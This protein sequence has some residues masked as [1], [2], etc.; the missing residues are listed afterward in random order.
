MER[1]AATEYAPYYGKYVGLVTEDDLVAALEVQL[2]ETLAFLRGVAE[3]DATVLHLSYTWTIKEVV[4]HLTDAERVF[5]YRALR[6]GRGD[7]TPLPGFDENPYV[8]TGQFNRITLADLVNEFELVRRSTLALFRHLPDEAWS[9]GGVAS[10]HPV[11]VRAL[12]AILIGHVRHHMTIVRR[13]L[14]RA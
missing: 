9:R 14:N 2:G 8:Q 7:E 6:F 3:D 1:P 12:A 11:T 5:A 10:D 13:R 4:G